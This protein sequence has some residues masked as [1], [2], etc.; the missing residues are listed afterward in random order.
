M[1]NGYDAKL[2]LDA[3]MKKENSMWN[4]FIDTLGSTKQL[5]CDFCDKANPSKRCPCSEVIYCN[6]E[7]QRAHWSLHK[8][9]VD[10][11]KN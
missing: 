11:N 7:C 10:H 8:L 6:T 9:G 2:V 4:F 3:W 5:A 1:D